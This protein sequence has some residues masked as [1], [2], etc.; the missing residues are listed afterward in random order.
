MLD[1]LAILADDFNDEDQTIISQ[2]GI[3][4]LQQF[5]L[6]KQT[7][8]PQYTFSSKYIPPLFYTLLEFV[9][10]LGDKDYYHNDIKPENIVL[11]TFQQTD[12]Q[13]QQ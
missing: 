12:N 3:I 7:K 10:L 2:P 1:S 8:N 13:Y 9:L 11:T 5:M 4:N 6:Y